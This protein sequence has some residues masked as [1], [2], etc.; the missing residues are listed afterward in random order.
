MAYKKCPRCDLN[1]IDEKEDLCEVCKKELGIGVYKT[2]STYPSPFP[3]EITI[4]Q[5]DTDTIKPLGNNPGREGYI[6]YGAD[7]TAYGVVF[8]TFEG[9]DREQDRVEIRYYNDLTDQYGFWHRLDLPTGEF[10]WSY[11]E[12]VLQQYGVFTGYVY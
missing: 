12:R 7:G 1:W 8:H 10:R 4:K 6:L 11:L 3:M 2:K 5:S 9:T